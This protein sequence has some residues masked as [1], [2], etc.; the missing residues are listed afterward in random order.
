[1]PR[2]PGR[3]GTDTIAPDGSKKV[4]RVARFGMKAVLDAVANQIA[5]GQQVVEYIKKFE[6]ANGPVFAAA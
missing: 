6:K 3:P 2:P 5:I 4:E 1:M